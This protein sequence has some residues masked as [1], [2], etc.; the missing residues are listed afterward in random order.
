MHACMYVYVYVYV[1]TRDDVAALRCRG[2]VTNV[3]IAR[4]AAW[5]TDRSEHQGRCLAAQQ[6]ESDAC[7]GGGLVGDVVALH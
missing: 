5:A 6:S 7:R 2:A 4:E 1:Y 3:C